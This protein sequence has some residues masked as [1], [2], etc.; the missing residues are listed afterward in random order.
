MF[1]QLLTACTNK[2]SHKVDNYENGKFVNQ[3]IKYE[4]SF[5]KLWDIVVAYV[6]ADREA[7][8]PSNPIPVNKISR[9][10]LWSLE[11]DT[12]FRLGHSSVLVQM[13]GKYILLDPVFSERASFSQWLGPKRFHQPPINIEE[14]P[15]IDVVVISHDHYDHLDKASITQLKEKVAEF[16]VPLGLAEY[17]IEWGVEAHRITELN[18]WQ[19]H[20]VGDITFTA[21]PAQH[22]SG[23][24]L[25]DKDTTLWAS[26]AIKS[27]STS[28]FYS[29]DTGYFPGFKEI[30]EKLGPFDLTLIETGAYNSLWS[31]IHMLPE[32]SV[33]AH[34]DLQGNYMIPVHN[35]TFDLA[36]HDWYEPLVRASN[37]AA[38]HNVNLLT[39]E[40]GSPVSIKQPKSTKAWWTNL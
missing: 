2:P 3:Y 26:W 34:M 5:T 35:A 14:L 33:K 28:L 37:S 22:F 32:E 15:E 31:E 27:N 13:S 12:L 9:E 10:L 11:S 20:N 30:G 39:P 1:S 7:A 21:T 17:L 23:R 25:T 8:I 19:H 24:G 38:E 16:V 4:N 18:W 40:I 29:G 6:K 36:L